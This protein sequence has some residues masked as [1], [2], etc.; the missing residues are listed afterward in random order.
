MNNFQT[1]IVSFY[2]QTSLLLEY[3]NV[4][5]AVEDFGALHGRESVLG[6]H[7]D[8]T[9]FQSSINKSSQIIDFVEEWGHGGFVWNEVTPEEWL[10]SVIDSSDAEAKR[11]LKEQY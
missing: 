10:Q 8:A 3:I 5:Q 11:L 1:F 4:D 7:L 6:L 2:N 9:A